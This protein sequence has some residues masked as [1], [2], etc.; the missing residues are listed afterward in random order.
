MS[1][2]CIII[3]ILAAEFLLG[4]GVDTPAYKTPKKAFLFSL[5]PGGGQLYNGKWV[6][7]IMFIGLEAAA[8]NAWLENSHIYNDYDN[9]NYPLRKHRYLEIRTVWLV[10][11]LYLSVRNAG[12]CGGC[13]PAA[14]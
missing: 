12:C 11:G 4:Q 13:P 3:L 8:T 10:E 9:G 14:I 2:R 5:S 7:A 6:K 1:T